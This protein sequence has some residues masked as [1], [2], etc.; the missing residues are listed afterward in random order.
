MQVHRSGRWVVVASTT[1]NS[2]AVFPLQLPNSSQGTS[3]QFG[4]P[5]IIHTELSGMFVHE[6]AFSPDHKFLYALCRDSDWVR[7]YQFDN[8]TGVLTVIGPNDGKAIL[9]AK[10]GPHHMAFHPFLD[11]AYVIN[12][13]N[14]S[15]ARFD[16]DRKDTGML[17]ADFTKNPERIIT[18][19]P[20]NLPPLSANCT[21]G[22]TAACPVYAISEVLVSPDGRFVYASNR[23][24]VGAPNN[25]VI[26]SVSPFDGSLTAIA[27]EDGGG[28]II[29]AR[30]M[31]LSPGKAG[32]YLF[33]A[34]ENGNSVTVFRR[35]QFT[36][37][38][39]KTQTL[40]TIAWV[41]R[42]SFIA[43]LHSKTKY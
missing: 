27:W 13:L 18:T 43:L 28:D 23:G 41:D 42:P 8:Q 17:S 9:P 4:T 37:L 31:S 20:P 2:L 32:A 33:V 38:L 40:S 10:S 35:D 26:F 19:L 15:I 14:S 11:V 24:I 1:N 3:F 36:G 7:M 34:N 39:T 22:V 12:T 6:A 30:H 29:F 25:I 5:T 16:W 21:A